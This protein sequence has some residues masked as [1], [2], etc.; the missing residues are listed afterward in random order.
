MSEPK[1]VASE[2][3]GRLVGNK[4][5]WVYLDD[6]YDNIS[7]ATNARSMTDMA[8]SIGLDKEAFAS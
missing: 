5:F 1:A 2:C 4:A 8:T 6:H 7:S 3:A